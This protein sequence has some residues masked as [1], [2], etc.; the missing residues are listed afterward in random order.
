MDS[1]NTVTYR[2]QGILK[3]W[4]QQKELDTDSSKVAPLMYLIDLEYKKYQEL[5]FWCFE[6][7]LTKGAWLRQ[8]IKIIE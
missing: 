1:M 4:K 7:P 5:C 2:A 6:K 3:R 8:E